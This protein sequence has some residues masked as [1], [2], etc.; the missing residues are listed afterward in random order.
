[1]NVFRQEKL[2]NL[3]WFDKKYIKI[4]NH[5]A[6]LLCVLKGNFCYLIVPPSMVKYKFLKS[7][8]L[9]IVRPHVV[10]FNIYLVAVSNLVCGSIGKISI[11]IVVKDLASKSDLVLLQS[12]DVILKLGK[13]R[14]QRLLFWSQL[15]LRKYLDEKRRKIFLFCGYW[16][17]LDRILWRGSSVLVS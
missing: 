13:F 5:V 17:S 10:T 11:G 12:V 3:R 1:M 16:P 8:F 2:I 9:S 14:I 7:I 15:D 6:L 4:R